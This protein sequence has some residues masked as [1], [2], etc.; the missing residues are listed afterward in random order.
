MT[1]F[2]TPYED[3]NAIVAALASGI[4]E[5][6][7]ASFVGIYLD[8]SLAL[9]D[10][11]PGKSDIDFVAVT[12]DEVTELAFGALQALHARLAAGPSRWGQELEGSYISRQAIGARDPRP[13]AQPYI[14]RG[15]ELT[16]VH[17]ERGYW[18]I[19]RHVLREH[20]VTVVGPPP[21]TLIERVEPDDLRAAVIGI[22]EEWWQPMLRD[23]ARLGNVFY[24][25]YAVLTMVRMRHTLA[26]GTIATK[27][28]AARWAHDALDPRWRLL[29]QHALAWSRD[30][31]PDLA[32]TLALIR[33]TCGAAG[34]NS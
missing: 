24:R 14:D 19:H 7:G 18:V 25:C 29:V 34:L 8:G 10:F 17:Q 1:G 28:A 26:H 32:A 23:R 5:A 9:G 2:P 15:D 6:L 3:V 13:A 4:Q 22:L 27:P 20:G 21:R 11:D 30:T 33:E 31:P 16:L 12:E